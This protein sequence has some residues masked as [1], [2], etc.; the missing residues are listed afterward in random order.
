MSVPFVLISYEQAVAA[1]AN[2]KLRGKP[3]K[4]RAFTVKIT[5]KAVVKQDLERGYGYS[6]QSLFPDFP[7]LAQYGKTFR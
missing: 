3:P 2:T 1:A 6:H 4:A 5:N 7:G